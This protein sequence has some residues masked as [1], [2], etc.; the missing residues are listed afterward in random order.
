[1]NWGGYAATGGE[2]DG[3]TSAL[4][5]ALANPNTRDL[6]WEPHRPYRLAVTRG[7]QVDG[8]TGWVDDLPV[9]HLYA[10]G[11]ELTGLMVWSEVFARC[12]DPPAAVRWS[13]LC[14][15]DELGVEHRPDR[16]TV[17]YQ[18]VLD[19]GCSNTDVRMAADDRSVE[20]WTS[21]ERTVR[22]GTTLPFGG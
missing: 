8:W 18:D 16:L 12:D 9:R 2:L 7:E 13:D 19:G 3:S 10:G 1:V 21:T 20:Q 22:A 14:V 11:Q 5:S 6:T 15:R 17:S 4:P